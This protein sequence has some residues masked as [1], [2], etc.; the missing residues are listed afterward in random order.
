VHN[1]AKSLIFAPH[2]DDEILSCGGYILK[3]LSEGN[4]VKVVLLTAGSTGARKGLD[5][6]DEKF[7]EI[8]CS[9]FENA[10][11]ELGVSE[12]EIFGCDNDFYTG[13]DE[14]PLFHAS[15]IK[16]VIDSIKSF[17]P[18]I[19]FCP[20]PNDTH[21]VHRA[22]NLLVK[23][24]IYHCRTGAYNSHSDGKLPEAN[25]FFFESPES[26]MK[27]EAVHVCDISDF[28]EK[29]VEIF[30]KCYPDQA[31]EPFVNWPKLRAEYW[32]EKAGFKYGEAFKPAGIAKYLIT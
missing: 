24:C 32:G 5:V 21:R 14:T 26:D 12:H 3:E 4:E 6:D 19:I 27:P 25:L 2:P 7:T 23:E 13:A 11:N 10:I 15:V 20:Q 29:K 30:K 16:R 9:E 17:K 1:S 8:R 28:F 18:E 31:V 22:V